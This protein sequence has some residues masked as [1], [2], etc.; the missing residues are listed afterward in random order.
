MGE[1]ELK[2]LRCYICNSISLPIFC[3]KCE[4]SIL[5]PDI[6]KKV[7]N[8]LEIYS[9][10]RY[11]TIEPLLLLKY[12][13]EGFRVLKA[14]ARITFRK[15][16]KEFNTDTDEVN[17]IGIDER[18]K[19]GYSH[20]A[21]MTHQMNIKGVNILHSSLLSKNRVNYAGK[22][23]DF[24]KNNPRNFEYNGKENISVILV[25]DIITTGTTLIEAQEILKKYNVTV[26]FALVLAD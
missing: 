24:R 26:D 9:F 16:V 19:N 12:K 10:Y 21:C 11:S 5:I 20:I 15:F 25:D 14:L 13:P 8:N 6:R 23:L 17:I 7:I 22:N 3:K 18:V 2:R 4:E 1:R